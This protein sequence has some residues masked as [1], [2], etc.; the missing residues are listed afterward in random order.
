MLR[1]VISAS[2]LAA[3]SLGLSSAYADSPA[4]DCQ[5]HFTSEGSFFAGKKFSTWVEFANVTKPD[6]Y[7]RAYTAIS[8]DGY[9]IVS[10]DRETG[11]IS[12]SQSVSYGKGTT[13]PLIIVV[14]PS[15]TTGS[16]LTATFRI[17]GGQTVKPEIVRSKL[18]EYLGAAPSP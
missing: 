6:A 16:K 11:I 12:A 17:G 9:Q 1:T 8:K 18:C 2:L 13:A 14:E 4:I 15:N 10:Q 7:S 3:F 5:A